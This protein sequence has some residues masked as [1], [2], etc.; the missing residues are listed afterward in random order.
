M[1]QP[2]NTHI[3][4]MNWGRLSYDWE[5]KR[6]A[7]FVNNLDLVN[8]VAARSKGFVWRLSDEDMNAEQS[9]S[10][11]VF[12]GDQRIASTLSVWKTAT[13]FVNFVHHTIHAGFMAKADNW[14]DRMDAVKYVIWPVNIGHQPNMVEAKEMLDL[15][16]K[17][18]PS[19]AAYNFSYLDVLSKTEAVA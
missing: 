19:H 13:D 7:E 18:G 6:V 17:N 12:G 3:A 15:L 2:Q 5:D 11:G 14:L 8:G 4:H 10:E 9:N 1:K 16:S